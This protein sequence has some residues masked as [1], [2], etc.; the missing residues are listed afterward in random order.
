ML[1]KEAQILA[2]NPIQT[3]PIG[4]LLAIIFLVSITGV[5]GWMLHLP[6]GTERTQ[7]A[8]QTVK[9]VSSLRR[10]LVPLLS[11]NDITDRIV[12]LAAQMARYRDGSVELL[13]VLEVPF[14]LP[15]DAH[16]EEDE[17][18]A[19]ELLDRAEA[20]A[21]R[22][23]TKLTK[24]ILKARQAGTAIIHE[25]KEH[26][27]DM[28]LIANSPTRI[29]GSACQLDPVVEYVLKNTPCEVLVL[30]SGQTTKH[31]S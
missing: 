3:N 16:V 9:S 18:L 20:I 15:L 6:K 22:S 23:T 5:L 26:A 31:L 14:M 27:I 21:K 13:A 30:S 19:L 2:T 10:I 1:M 28:I 24:R 29:R 25:A 11:A 12:A 8:A 7:T 17:K 4:A